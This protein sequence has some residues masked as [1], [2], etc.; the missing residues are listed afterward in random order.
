GGHRRGHRRGV[1]ATSLGQSGGALSLVDRAPGQ[2]APPDSDER[3]AVW[4]GERTGGPAAARQRPTP[5]PPPKTRAQ[6][7]KRADPDRGADIACWSVHAP[8]SILC[9]AMS[10]K[11]VA[12]PDKGSPSVTGV[13]PAAEREQATTIQERKG[14][15]HAG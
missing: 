3:P 5:A 14:S 8:P 4:S 13:T 15:D 9:Y 12:C 1:T 2:G 10:G 7:E 6:Q 11:N